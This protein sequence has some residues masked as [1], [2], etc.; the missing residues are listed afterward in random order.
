[1]CY[2]LRNWNNKVKFQR[3]VKRERKVSVSERKKMTVDWRELRNEELHIFF[4]LTKY[5]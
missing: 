2:K 4:L 5:Y 3:N 1:M